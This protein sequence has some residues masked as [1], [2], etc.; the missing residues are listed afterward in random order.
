LGFCF[1][2]RGDFAPAFTD[3]LC[4]GL[5]VA[6]QTLHGKPCRQNVFCRVDVSVMVSA[7]PK[8]VPFPDIQRQFVND[9][10]TIS[11]SLWTREPAINFN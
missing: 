8:T 3:L 10:A 1:R 11:T 2:P 7:A 5:T 4:S 9:V 6:P